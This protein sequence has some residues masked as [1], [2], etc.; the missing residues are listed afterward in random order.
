MKQNSNDAH[1]HET[2]GEEMRAA[3]R[4][5]FNQFLIWLKPN[6]AEPWYIDAL[7]YFYKIPAVILLI[8][9]SPLMLLVLLFTFIVAL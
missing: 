9:C 4:R 1:E 3:L 6:A 7:R 2:L 8:V 5:N